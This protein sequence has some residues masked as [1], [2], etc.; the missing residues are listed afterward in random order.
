MADVIKSP[1]T[2]VGQLALPSPKLPSVTLPTTV[3]NLETA[4]RRATYN[5]QREAYEAKIA[6]EQKAFQEQVAN[7]EAGYAYDMRNLSDYNDPNE[8]NSFAD[9]F[10]NWAEDSVVAATSGSIS[11][12]LKTFFIQGY[13]APIE[14]AVRTFYKPLIERDWNSLMF[15]S[16][17][18]FAETADI[19]ANPVKGMLLDEAGP[20]AG[21][22]KATG[23]G[24]DGRY[25][26]DFDSGSLLGDIA[27]EVVAD[28][29]NW[30]TLGGKAIATG[31]AKSITKSGSQQLIAE[32]G[33]RGAKQFTRNLAK[34]LPGN[35]ID[36]AL[37]IAA[38]A[39]KHSRNRKLLGS[40]TPDALAV[41]K[42]NALNQNSYDV[43][44]SVMNVTK[45]AS[46][47]DDMII[48]VAASSAF[49]FAPT[50][51]SAVYKGIK[52][53]STLGTSR[54]TISVF[55]RMLNNMEPYML[56]ETDVVAMTQL[57]PAMQAVA[58]ELDS[59]S[60]LVKEG[61]VMP[62]GV[63]E[64]I[65][66]KTAIHEKKQLSGIVGEYFTKGENLVK[67][68]NDYV[69]KTYPSL[70]NF[71]NY[72]EYVEHLA[73]SY[74]HYND[75]NL[76]LN[77]VKMINE[78][79]DVLVSRNIK[80]R[81]FN[82]LSGKLELIRNAREELGVK[83]TNHN[84]AILNPEDTRR[85]MHQLGEAELENIRS[86]ANTVK[87]QRRTGLLS[88]D[89]YAL[90][91]AD[92]NKEYNSLKRFLASNPSVSEFQN[93][94]SFIK[95]FSVD[96]EMFRTYLNEIDRLWREVPDTFEG[97]ALMMDEL[98]DIKSIVAF[99]TSMTGRK[100]P[101]VT[102]RRIE[103][104]YLR[105]EDYLGA[106]VDALATEYTVNSSLTNIFRYM[107]G[108][109]K[110]VLDNM[111]ANKLAE[112]NDGIADS[113]LLSKVDLSE[114]FIE[115]FELYEGSSIV[116]RDFFEQLPMGG[117]YP[118]LL[119]NML[120]DVVQVIEKSKDTLSATQTRKV[121]PL[122]QQMS[123]TMYTV[124]DRLDEAAPT[125]VNTAI[126][127]EIEA[128][129][130]LR[131][132]ANEIED[133]IQLNFDELMVSTDP[134][135]KVYQAKSAQVDTMLSL[136]Q[137]EGLQ[138]FTY[139][140]STMLGMG[141]HLYSLLKD[142]EAI[143]TGADASAQRVL[144]M[145]SGMHNYYNFVDSWLTAPVRDT[146]KMAVL[147]TMQ[148]FAR[149]PLEYVAINPEYYLD[150]VLRSAEEW[151]NLGQAKRSIS[152]S[153]LIETHK[154]DD[155]FRQILI[156][157]QAALGF[158][159]IDEYLVAASHDARFDVLANRYIA[160]L[161]LPDLPVDP[162]KVKIWFDIETL[163][164][165]GR[166]DSLF[167]LAYYDEFTG[168]LV[169]LRAKADAL[170]PPSVRRTLSGIDDEFESA[171]WFRANYMDAPDLMTEEELLTAFTEYI[172][173]YR[174]TVTSPV[175]AGHNIADFDTPFLRKRLN[176]YNL[177]RS[178]NKIEMIDTLQYLRAKEGYEYL[179]E[180][181]IDAIKL[182]FTNYVQSREF[183]LFDSYTA[184]NKIP[185]S[186]TH[187]KKFIESPGA[188]FNSA[189]AH[190]SA[191][192]KK[193]NPYTNQSEIIGSRTFDNL[194]ENLGVTLGDIGLLNRE[195][196]QF[197]LNVDESY[198]TRM[199]E[200]GVSNVTSAMNKAGGIKLGDAKYN[201]LSY[202]A[203]TANNSL[204]DFFNR[205][206]IP[207]SISADLSGKYS[208]AVKRMQRTVKRIDLVEELTTRMD[209]MELYG[210]WL[211][212][213]ISRFYETSYLRQLKNADDIDLPPDLL[214]EAIRNLKL[215]AD[216]PK[217]LF[218]VVKEL[219]T[220]YDFIYRRG[221]NTYNEKAFISMADDD[222][223]AIMEYIENP[224]LLGYNESAYYAAFINPALQKDSVYSDGIEYFRDIGML[225]DRQRSVMDMMY[226][227]ENV[228][229]AHNIT[230][231]SAKASVAAMQVV[232][233]PFEKLRKIY[234]SMHKEN[235]TSL[236]AKTSTV[237][238]NVDRMNRIKRELMH[239]QDVVGYQMI[240]EVLSYE[241][242]DLLSYLYHEAF[243]TV[244]FDMTDFRFKGLDG[245]SRPTKAVEAYRAMLER[246]PEYKALGIEI[247]EEGGA[248]YLVLNKNKVD[249]TN[250]HKLKHTK[251]FDMRH[252]TGYQD[253]FF[254]DV[255]KIK[256]KLN[257][258]T[259]NKSFRT[260]GEVYSPKTM[261]LVL[262]KLPPSLSKV[263]FD[264]DYY[265]SIKYFDEV[266]F[267]K[268]VLGTIN[269]KKNFVP[270]YSQ[271][272]MK[273]QSLAMQEVIRR[274][275][276]IRKYTMLEFDGSNAPSSLLFKTYDD[277]ALFS[278]LST[279][280]E[281][282][283]STVVP[284]KRRGLRLKTM[285][286]HTVN[287][288]KI[289]RAK[290]YVIMP[291]YVHNKAQE[292]IN[293]GKFTEP[294]LK[295]FD[296]YVVGPTK[297][298]Y[299]SSIGLLFRNLVDSSVKN[300][301][302]SDGLDIIPF[303][304]EVMAKY[305]EYNET[306]GLITHEFGS[307]NRKTI[308]EYFDNNPT[309]DRELF[310][311][312][313]EFINDGPSAGMSAELVKYYDDAARILY[314]YS[315]LPEDELNL[316]MVRFALEA[317]EPEI[318]A[319]YVPRTAD[320]LLNLKN[321]HQ[322][323]KRAH[324]MRQYTKHEALTTDRLVHYLK[325]PDEVPP[326]LTKEFTKLL[327]HQE[328]WGIALAAQ[329]AMYNNFSQVV[330]TANGY[331]EQIFRL[332]LYLDSI[333]KGYSH[334]ESISRV[335]KAHF[336]PTRKSTLERGME[337]LFP[338][339]SFTL[340]N[341]HFWADS[342][343]NNGA[344]GSLFRDIMTPIWNF[345]SYD[346]WDI[347]HR[348]S[349]QYQILAGNVVMNPKTTYSPYLD[350]DG[351]PKRNYDG[352]IRQRSDTMGVTLKLNPSIMDSVQLLLDPENTI[353]ERFVAP[354]RVPIEQM[355]WQDYEYY[356]E[357]QNAEARKQL[358]LEMVPV[359]GVY[360]QRRTSGQRY[361]A[362]T[363]NL[364]NKVLPSLFGR[365]KVDSG[366]DQYVGNP[367]YQSYYD[368]PIGRNWREL[369][370]A[371]KAVKQYVP[372][373]SD[374][375][376]EYPDYSP[377]YNY[378][379]V[380]KTYNQMIMRNGEAKLTRAARN[381][382]YNQTDIYRDLYT[383]KGTSRQTINMMYP[384]TPKTLEYQVKALWN[385]L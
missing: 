79:Y 279:H 385:F 320:E 169:E 329:K 301:V 57:D 58:K 175:L 18:N 127:K 80:G 375:T 198:V 97:K 91:R 370:K 59:N 158:S 287:D 98:T 258:Y 144:S 300:V 210:Q 88:E 221:N 114:M 326:E 296:K 106:K 219:R 339:A 40:L 323:V 89:E 179:T 357:A 93:H 28:P 363:H 150:K 8:V 278:Y 245:L 361:Y 60:V 284:D 218:A 277:D 322:Y 62:S 71:K 253:E 105:Y 236:L 377:K 338:F 259:H 347:A 196:N 349:V 5:R 227:L 199:T 108:D 281:Y 38:K 374:S 85:S 136:Y 78:T 19:I 153:N 22:K 309:K 164:L 173:Q 27:L 31:A 239:Y 76:L 382:K 70:G 350:A 318:R 340:K 266:T 354:L 6:A 23:W 147:D 75:F 229:D 101:P 228:S 360:N 355:L 336:D 195:Y 201:P 222:I 303:T 129:N 146:F 238:A 122:M 128:A 237:K 331:M 241:P 151:L 17:Y 21:F 311:I 26:Y 282:K 152:L 112:Y 358:W 160:S 82:V 148:S 226:D 285:H 232:Y 84:R 248:I 133:K 54:A 240:E 273:N 325:H 295:M 348:M 131:D 36:D 299:L 214:P 346:T 192:T 270:F 185:V 113:A 193:M 121:I 262:S 217:E 25:N 37:D 51:L 380:S 313:H 135:V 182:R 216:T 272:I 35:Q 255:H 7:T 235:T 12:F 252:Y 203:L 213:E 304:F 234:Q 254:E 24:V 30:I 157:N 167:Q 246:A 168:K 69:A 317:T 156:D 342:L 154:T 92:V 10:Y 208:K 2:K 33:E 11:E 134:N 194:R 139:E 359:Y 100:V 119:K 362:D 283:L 330:L 307:F 61:I 110:H 353:K 55:N 123:Y 188:E 251:D 49:G 271:N 294:L 206:D 117:D 352:S 373:L 42:S 1:F 44:K 126:G 223:R 4:R 383:A 351:N 142:T 159:D 96:P 286:V 332:S 132:F 16:L 197:L 34:A 205:A 341:M 95:L 72:A 14:L 243:G 13:V 231:A 321:E 107:R 290:E 207:E 302:M 143:A 335:I 94:D 242:E 191:F 256:D 174:N 116:L 202:K 244:V 274:M 48:K 109:S 141:P 125:T 368:R 184:Y 288:V 369:N 312:I 233:E 67:A 212:Q 230:S 257:Y 45:A 181:E 68:L 176:K 186:G 364:L 264:A 314:R 263:A 145:A 137:T 39:F 138:E 32:L 183:E 372:G 178:L 220:K 190:V 52:G 102:L 268:S 180:A 170:P 77:Q 292:V 161:E 276:S 20:A 172:G 204:G 250:I 43:I 90:I 371:Q 86:V 249:V 115:S 327:G 267:N 74:V 334:N 365:T 306:I 275:S 343:M 47:L 149:T 64:H 289:A 171:E 200:Y 328:E 308:K 376:Y 15:N 305:S 367:N 187:H 3:F 63:E 29:L 41:L 280:P 53:V 297:L 155:A 298:G 118:E 81:Q 162:D 310:K 177:D 87:E 124:A 247:H 261:D 366:V 65:L 111:R 103:E 50:V 225:A 209:S 315:K 211:R 293:E 46:D 189:L 120:D 344:V 104:L 345:D 337:V 163:G 384:I 140:I 319:K 265:R 66:I 381:M 260:T 224:R 73:T 9:V 324:S 83:M 316:D 333:K 56:P 166:S 165:E 99:E 269:N 130:I 356:D 378:K 379:N 291:E 215:N